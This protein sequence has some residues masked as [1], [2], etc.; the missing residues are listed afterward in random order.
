ME[1]DNRNGALS[2]A[3]GLVGFIPIF[4]LIF[5]V[6]SIVKGAAGINK[7]KKRTTE[8]NGYESRALSIAGMVIG[9][10]SIIFNVIFFI[11]FVLPFLLV[12]LLFWVCCLQFAE[13]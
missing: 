9:I 1:S 6:L 12:G 13:V 4:G 7:H 5:G 3:F 11:Y 8:M 10:I 2:L